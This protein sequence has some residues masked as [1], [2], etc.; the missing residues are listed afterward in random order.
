MHK[1]CLHH[2][3][4][5][6]I[7]K[8]ILSQIFFWEKN[9]N[10]G[11]L[12]PIAHGARVFKNFRRSII[13][14]TLF[15]PYLRAILVDFQSFWKRFNRLPW[16]LYCLHFIFCFRRLVTSFRNT[17][18]TLRIHTQPCFGKF[19]SVNETKG[20]LRGPGNETLKKRKEQTAFYNR[21]QPLAGSGNYWF[22][23]RK[24]LE[25]GRSE[26]VSRYFLSAIAAS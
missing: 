25:H 2:Q 21:F 26:G 8:S 13:N 19:R 20:D 16:K 18:D 9:C 10:S 12:V 24:R 1:G 7:W 3:V 17:G 15:F 23:F 14:I 5:H 11:R 6:A 4:C 22:H